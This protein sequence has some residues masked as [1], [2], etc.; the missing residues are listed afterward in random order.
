MKC[1]TKG[2][3]PPA[4]DNERVFDLG[5]LYAAL[6]K[7][8]DTRKARGKRYALALVLLLV[9]LAK[10]CGEDRPLGIAQ[11][12]RARAKYLATALQLCYAGMPSHNTIRRILQMVDPSA[13]Q[14]IENV[15]L[16]AK[17][18]A[19]RSVLIAIDGKTLRGTICAGA[20]QGVHLLA[21]FLPQE[22]L[23]LAQI[24]VGD[25][26][27]EIVGAPKLL[28]C[29]D[30]RGKVVVADAMLTQ[31]ELSEQ[32]VV[33]GGHFIW[34]AKD[35]QPTVHQTIADLFRL[36][37]C[38]LA[39]DKAQA[40]PSTT[41]VNKGHGRMETRALT[42]S[43]L[44]NDYLKWP[45]LG[46]VFRIERQFTKLNDGSIHAEVVYGLTDL[47]QAEANPAQLLSFVRDYW[48]IEND[49][50]YRRDK[51]LQEDGTRM[52]RPK[53]AQVMATINNLVLSLIL[54]SGW[55]FLPEARRHYDGH[56]D[57]ALSLILRSP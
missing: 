23:V 30:L 17:D 1:S 19:E 37:S 56:P 54:R 41:T 21:A 32:I 11:W 53:M 20:S 46:Q 6:A 34:L 43:E 39:R 44:L 50:H 22:G 8:V 49:L 55:Q 57:E 9:I 35:N 10:L 15:F 45:H 48:N 47:K 52:T 7:L 51:T 38:V 3:T 2:I 24:A 33:A 25:K 16:G 13:V 42:A 40:F 4:T 12:A 14:T 18:A 31:R 29:L 36:P 27:N 28:E 5:G 26:E